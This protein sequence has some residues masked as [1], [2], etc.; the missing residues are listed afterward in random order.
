MK[1][2][3]SENKPGHIRAISLWNPHAT[4]VVIGEKK[5]ETRSFPTLVRGRVAIH[6]ALNEEW[7]W[8]CG[9]QPFFGSLATHKAENLSYGYLLGTVEITDCLKAEGTRTALSQKEITFGNYD[10]GRYAWKLERPI[11]FAEPV[12]FTGHQLFFWVPEDILP[13]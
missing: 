7:K 9:M 11:R 4:L 13:V 3:L 6:A 8:M 10:D 2:S 1:A 12:K 5:W